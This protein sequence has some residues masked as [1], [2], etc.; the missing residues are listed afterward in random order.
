[1]FSKTFGSTNLGLNGVL[2]TVE[3]DIVNG[4]PA[5]DKFIPF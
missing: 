3:V 2:I 5:L 1:M 4:L